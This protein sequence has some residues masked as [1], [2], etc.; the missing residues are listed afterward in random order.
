LNNASTLYYPDVFGAGQRLVEFVGEAYFEIAKEKN[1]RF[2]VQF[3]DIS[4]E[5]LGTIFIVRAYK[6]ESQK[7]ITLLSGAVKVKNRNGEPVLLRPGEQADIIAGGIVRS[8]AD[9]TDAV[10]W[11]NGYFNFHSCSLSSVLRQLGRWYDMDVIM[12]RTDQGHVFDGRISKSLSLKKILD[13][14]QGQDIKI[15]VVGDK[16]IATR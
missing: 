2:I 11:K 5:V 4:V 13:N 1:R 12:Q 3:N 15:T 7:N 14:L 8:I 10:A 9:T 6:D 16:L